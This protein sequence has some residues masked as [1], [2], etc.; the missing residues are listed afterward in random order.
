MTF[1][2]MS[3]QFQIIYYYTELFF[4]ILFIFE[5]SLVIVV[6]KKNYIALR[7]NQIELIIYIAHIVALLL[8]AIDKG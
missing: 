4:A 2:G 3:F 7:I 8:L 1:K 6:Y 5:I